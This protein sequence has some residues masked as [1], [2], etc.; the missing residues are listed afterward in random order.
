MRET[1]LLSLFIFW[2][3][4]SRVS[5]VLVRLSSAMKNPCQVMR[6][7]SWYFHELI[8]ATLLPHNY[9]LVLLIEHRSRSDLPKG[10]EHLFCALLVRKMGLPGTYNYAFVT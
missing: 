2:L 8:A 7:A 4:L 5:K 3:N 9:R 10:F 1:T 6:G